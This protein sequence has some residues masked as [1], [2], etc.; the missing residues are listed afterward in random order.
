MVQLLDPT[1]GLHTA[2]ANLTRLYALLNR[3]GSYNVGSQ[4]D[5]L[6]NHWTWSQMGLSGNDDWRIPAIYTL[7][8]ASP[9]YV[10]VYV[11]AAM[12]IYW[13]FLPPR[14]SALGQR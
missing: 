13:R 12:A 8:E 2:S 5:L 14:T 4:C 7:M 10:Q 3:T 1:S 6:D 11:D 9:S